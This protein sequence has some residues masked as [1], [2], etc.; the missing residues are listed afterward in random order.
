MP[1]LAVADN[2]VSVRPSISWLITGKPHMDLPKLGLIQYLSATVGT[3]K[4]W[5]EIV[6]DSSWLWETVFSFYKKSPQ[7]TP[8]D[9]QKIGPGFDLPYDPSAFSPQGGPLQL[10]FANYQQPVS[11]FLSKGMEAA[12]I[13]QQK[14]L[15]SGTLNGYAALTVCVDPKTETRSSSEAS[16]LQTAFVKTGLKVYPHTMAKKILF[17]VKKKATG[18]DV[19]TEGKAFTLSAKREIIVSAGAVSKTRG[20]LLELN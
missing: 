18:V 13:K 11:P 2:M 10:S 15:D 12:G 20:A 3:F 19:V 4:W 7:F 5:A 6:G 1:D 9:L 8:P 14:G 16:F 17:D